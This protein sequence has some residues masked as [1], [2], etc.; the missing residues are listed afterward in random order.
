MLSPTIIERPAQ[1][2]AGRKLNMSYAVDR[3]PQLWQSFM[4]IKKHI[5]QAIGEALY[6]LQIYPPHFFDT[7]NPTIEF[8]KWA[9]IA[10]SHGNDL[11]E[12]IVPFEMPGGWYALFHHK[13]MDKSIFNEIYS[14]WLPASGYAL[15][16]RPH[17]EV[18]GPNYKQGSDDSEE[19]IW[20]PIKKP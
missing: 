19:E 20:I 9:L 2:L 18:L 5:H 8:E 10:V 1:L 13:G 6:S 16:D 11:P 17:F 14:N 15:D 7:F 4:P 3:T 12:H